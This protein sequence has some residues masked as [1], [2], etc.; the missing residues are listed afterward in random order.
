MSDTLNLALIGSGH[1]GGSF[2]LALREAGAQ[3]HIT[4]F[5]SDRAQAEL[6]QQRG[7]ADAIASSA[8]DATRG[9]DIVM[10]ATPL[11]SYAALAAEIA[12][13]LGAHAIV[14]DL[15][16]VK[17]SMDALKTTLPPARL[18]PGHPIAGGEKTGA[19]VASGELFRGKLCI[20]TGDDADSSAVETIETLWHLAGA[21]VLRMPTQVHDSIYAY[22]SHLP[23]VIAFV[24]AELFFRLGVRVGDEQEVLQRFLRISRS[25]ARMWA[26]I[27]LENRETLL[28]AL[29]TYIAVLEHFAKELRSGK[30][31][32]SPAPAEIAARFVPRILAGSLI[33][34]VSLYEQQ[35]GMSL[36][37]FGAGGMRDIVAPAAIDPES[38]FEAMSQAAPSIAAV[39]EQALVL[40]REVERSIGSE[41]AE[42]LLQYFTA[43]TAHAHELIRPRQ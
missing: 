22:V 36:R 3:V 19:A 24:A 33:S 30:G 34:A 20:L 43:C 16:S 14:T 1:L 27:A 9:A 23:H 40:L 35:S 28:S 21:D 8:A 7:G 17:R 6:L 29:S 2:A 31:E 10:L 25:N 15:G 39:I 5:D 42:A 26:D 32:T 11:R 18:V 12:P 41:D 38:E 13:A 4:A 37:P